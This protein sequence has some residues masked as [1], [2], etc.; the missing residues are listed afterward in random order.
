VSSSTDLSPEHV[1]CNLGFPPEAGI[2]SQTGTVSAALWQFEPGSTYELQGPVSALHVISA[3][4]KGRY[5]HTYFADGHR[6]WSR[7]QP[8]FHMNLVSSGEHPRGLFTGTQRF[9]VLH[10]YLPHSIVEG[11][12]RE[13]SAVADSQSITLIDPMCSYDPDVEAICR[14]VVREMA[15]PDRCARVML[16]AL[17][18]ALAIR[19]LRAHS[20]ISRSSMLAPK[21]TANPRDWRLRLA[22]DYLEAHVAED[23]G[24]QEI[25]DAAGLSITHLTTLFRDGTGE[26]PHRYLM[27]RRFER[28]CEMLANP[29]VSISD[30]A[31]LCGFANSGHLTTVVRKRLDMTPTEF[32]RNLLA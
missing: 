14:Q 5:H 24:L 10:I 25:A 12:A 3:P 21:G 8:A 26:P 6:K 22:I 30:V 13:C 23:V 9:T 11:L 31:H 17:A 28:A 20:N 18:H 2:T 16:D 19:L 7:M 15:N 29:C 32:R 4:V 27:R 1:H